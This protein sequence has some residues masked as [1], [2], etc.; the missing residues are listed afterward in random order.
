MTIVYGATGV[1]YAHFQGP[2]ALEPLT[3]FLNQEAL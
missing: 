3:E 2:D 1:G